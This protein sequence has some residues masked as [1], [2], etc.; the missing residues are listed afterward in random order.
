MKKTL[1]YVLIGCVLITATVIATV[2]LFNNHRYSKNFIIGNDISSIVDKYGEFDKVWYNDNE[3][4]IISSGW[5]IIS[6]RQRSLFG[7]GTLPEKYLI[8]RFYNGKAVSVEEQI[9]N[10]GG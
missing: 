9:R 5:Y 10:P 6:P 2:F 3:K 4:K 8:I 1:C 7:L